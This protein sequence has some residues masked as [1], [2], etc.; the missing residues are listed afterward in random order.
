LSGRPSVKKKKPKKDKEE[1]HR[2]SL[3][4]GDSLECE[5]EA[6]SPSVAA[7]ADRGSVE[8]ILSKHCFV[9]F[10]VPEE[11]DQIQIDTR[12]YTLG[13]PRTRILFGPHGPP[14]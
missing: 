2:F 13:R 4:L 7:A 14:I 3:R 1:I 12:I 9:M 5:K 8:W 6:T 11:K 10:C